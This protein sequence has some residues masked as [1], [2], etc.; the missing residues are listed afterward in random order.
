VRHDW[1]LTLETMRGS[2]RP[3]AGIDSLDTAAMRLSFPCRLRIRLR[4]GRTLELEGAQ[5]GS[6]GRP[7]EEQRR[8]VEEKCR[9]VGL[10]QAVA[11]A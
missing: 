5:P 11:A 4:S 7:L 6:C 8:M 3:G 1:K 2:R 10:E 9:L